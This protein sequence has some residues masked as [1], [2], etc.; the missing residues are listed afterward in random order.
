[1][2]EARLVWLEKE[3]FV[4]FDGAGH[5]VVLSSQDP[6][7]AVGLK[8]SDLLMVALA[9]CAAVDLVRILDKQRQVVTGLEIAVSGEQ[10]PKAPWAFAKLHLVY[11]LRGRGLKEEGVRK[12]VDLAEGKYCSVAASLRPQVE[13]THAIEM[14]EEPA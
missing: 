10:Q 6:H 14:S 13:I 7:D 3:K 2:A 4:G 11:R 9:G 12:A 5:P 8:P 1:V